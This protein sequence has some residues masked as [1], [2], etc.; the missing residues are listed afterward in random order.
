MQH[1]RRLRGLRDAL[2]PE[3]KKYKPLATPNSIAFERG[4]KSASAGLSLRFTA[5]Q[6]AGMAIELQ[7]FRPSRGEGTT[8]DSKALNFRDWNAELRAACKIQRNKD[9]GTICIVWP[10]CCIAVR[11]S[12]SLP[13]GTAADSQ[14]RDDPTTPGIVA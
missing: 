14:S 7:S 1:A 3:L 10:G 6:V 11:A 13:A 9:D 12:D 4:A 5:R 8:G 2:V